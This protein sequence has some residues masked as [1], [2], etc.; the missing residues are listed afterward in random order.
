[1]NKSMKRRGRV[2]SCAPVRRR[3]RRAPN[4]PNARASNDHK[5]E[6]SRSFERLWVEVRPMFLFCGIPLHK[7]SNFGV[8]VM[9][10]NAR[11]DE[12]ISL[13]GTVMFVIDKK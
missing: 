1:M 11:I 5:Q 7:I 13:S 9:W 4:A 6:E 2:R 10:S 8:D 3:A 12:L